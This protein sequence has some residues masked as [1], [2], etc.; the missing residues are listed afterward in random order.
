MNP[1]AGDQFFPYEF[2]HQDGSILCQALTCLMAWCLFTDFV[3][4]CDCSFPEKYFVTG[5][6]QVG[7]VQNKSEIALQCDLALNV[8]MTN[9][10]ALLATLVITRILLAIYC[11]C[12]FCVLVLIV[13]AVCK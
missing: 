3:R 8:A 9:P 1:G 11:N 12:C 5:R 2:P 7:F 6:F 13:I 4:K 10:K